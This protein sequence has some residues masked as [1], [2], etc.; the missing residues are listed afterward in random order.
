[1]K[2]NDFYKKKKNNSSIKM[3]TC[4][5][6]WTAKI[7]AHTEIDAVL[8]GDSLATVMHGHPTTVFA[9]CKMMKPHI[10]AVRKGLGDEA[11]I[12]A[13]MPFLTYR[14]ST[15]ETMKVIDE[16]MKAG[17]N[18]IKLEGLAGNKEIIK[19]IVESG[20]PVMGHLGF[21]PQ[22]IN[23]V[24]NSYV[25]GRNEVEAKE[26]LLASKLLEQLGCFS[27]VLE[28]VPSSVAQKITQAINIPTIGIGAG[29]ETSGQILVLQDLIGAD[30]DFSPKFLKKYLDGFNLIKGAV[31]QYCLDVDSKEFPSS[32]HC[33]NSNIKNNANNKITS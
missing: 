18:A 7:I 6:Y 1:M 14:K 4:Y 22:S 20:I 33:Y 25:K 27:I 31:N 13:D 21:T 30:S 11:F 17:A 3:V 19:H 12:I 32:Q 5:D 16:F 2:V 9:N 29:S 28:C 24:G 8:I 23:V 26:L 10:A 15:E